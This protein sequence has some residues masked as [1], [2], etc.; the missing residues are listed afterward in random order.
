MWREEGRGGE[1]PQCPEE[2]GWAVEGGVGV[3]CVSG[4]S[5]WSWS[6]QQEER[7]SE[8]PRWGQAGWQKDILDTMFIPVNSGKTSGKS[9]Q[10]MSCIRIPSGICIASRW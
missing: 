1:G 7:P 2:Q 3:G 4:A 8:E 9:S 10:G 5:G 6:T